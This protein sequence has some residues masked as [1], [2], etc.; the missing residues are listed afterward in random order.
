MLDLAE[1]ERSIIRLTKR[2][3]ET[4][5]ECEREVEESISEF[6]RLLFFLILWSL[7]SEIPGTV[8]SVQSITKDPCYSSQH[9][10]RWARS[11]RT[12]AGRVFPTSGAQSFDCWQFREGPH[13]RL[14][15]GGRNLYSVG[16]QLLENSKGSHQGATS[17]LRHSPALKTIRFKGRM[18]FA[19]QSA[20]SNPA[21]RTTASD[22]LQD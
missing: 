21:E 18:S 3:R 2:E 7:V 1:P 4:L 17:S 22:E 16:L 6:L 10:Q 15:N 13:R 9:A 8:A 5:I 12:K 19:I 14:C 20:T 11:T